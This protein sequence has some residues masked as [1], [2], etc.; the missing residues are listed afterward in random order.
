MDGYARASEPE[1]IERAGALLA[2][3][4]A[5]APAD[6]TPWLNYAGRENLRVFRRGGNLAGTL[7]LVPM[8]QFWGGHAV[9]LCGIAGVAIVPWERGCGVGTRMMSDALREVRN[10]GWPLA[11]LYP[12]TQPLYRR[13]GFEQA[14]SR[15]E[16][17]GP[18][19]ALPYGD[20]ALQMRAFRDEDLPAV[21]R[22]YTDVARR[23]AGWLDRGSYIWHRVRH[24]RGLNAYGYVIGAPGDVEGYVFLARKTKPTFH[25][26]VQVTDMVAATPRG[27]RR[28]LT[29]LADHAPISEELIWFSGADD[30]LLFLP[31]EQ[32][33][34]AQAGP[35]W[36]IRIVDVAQ[37]LGAR[38]FA[39][40][41]T[42]VLEIDVSDELLTENAGRWILE[43]SGGEGRVRRGGGGTLRCDARALASMYSG[44]RNATALAGLGIVQGTPDA[45]ASAD[46]IFAGP[47]PSMPD[48]F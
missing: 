7:I 46:A 38:G 28:L 35:A 16:I 36:M 12:A 10:D 13:V 26:D 14:G 41:L 18:L 17:R 22:V 31:R 9:R 48:Q 30:P 15:F 25:T 21:Q 11:A 8:G 19:N 44:Y 39:P 4:F 37:A 23:R 3:T 29:F 32:F 42:A 47:A 20:H 33:F 27:W 43:V 5:F 1:E 45:L 6:A 2:E 24:P 40:G 34:V